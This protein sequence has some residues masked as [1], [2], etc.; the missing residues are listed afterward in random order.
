MSLD[1]T[2]VKAIAHLARLGVKEENLPVYQTDLNQII[3]LVE[4]MQTV[5]T[6]GVLPL[7]H[8]HDAKQRLR[9]DQVTEE[10]LRDKFQAVAPSVEHGLFKVPKVIE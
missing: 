10:N 9:L 4:Q 1:L 3:N 7:A 5:D 2:E 8:P 6:Q